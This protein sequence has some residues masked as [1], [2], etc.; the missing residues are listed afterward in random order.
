MPLST[1]FRI[2]YLKNPV[3]IYE[4][5]SCKLMTHENAINFTLIFVCALVAFTVA[6][7]TSS[8]GETSLEGG[9]KMK[10]PE[11]IAT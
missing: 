6:V 10:S 7:I 5:T 8:S 2:T 3:N 4:N 1:L 9:E 11:M